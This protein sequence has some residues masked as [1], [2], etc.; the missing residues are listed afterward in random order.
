M[1]YIEYTDRGIAGYHTWYLNEVLD[2]EPDTVTSIQ[3]DGNE[4]NV[5]LRHFTNIPMVDSPIVRWYGDDAKF[6][7]GNLRV[8]TSGK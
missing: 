7:I 3:V 8:Y 1:M 2:V 4:L 5:I 6:I